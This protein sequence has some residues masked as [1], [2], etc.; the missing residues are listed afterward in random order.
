METSEITESIIITEIQ[1]NSKDNNTIEKEIEIIRLKKEIER[2]NKIIEETDFKLISKNKSIELIINYLK[3]L[4]NEDKK[5]IIAKI[6]KDIDFFEKRLASEKN[7]V[8]DQILKEIRKFFGKINLFENNFMDEDSMFGGKK[9]IFIKSEIIQ[10]K[11]HIFKDLL[12]ENNN[13]KKRLF[14]ISKHKK[15]LNI[16]K[17][18]IIKKIK[19][20]SYEKN[21]YDN[22][23][24]VIKDKIN[25]DNYLT[26]INNKIKKENINFQN[27]NIYQNYL[28]KYNKNQDDFQN[29]KINHQDYLIKNHIKQIQKENLNLE[30]NKYSKKNK[31]LNFKNE[32]IKLKIMK[33]KKNKEENKKND[34]IKNFVKSKDFFTQAIINFKNNKNNKNNKS[35]DKENE[36]FNNIIVNIEEKLD[37]MKK[38]ISEKNLK[39]KKTC[40]PEDY[41]TCKKNDNLKILEIK[42]NFNIINKKKSFQISK[43]KNQKIFKS[44]KD[45]KKTIILK[46]IENDTIYTFY[47]KKINLNNLKKK[48]NLGKKKILKKVKNHSL[49]KKL[50]INNFQRKKF[51]KYNSLE[52]PI[53]FSKKNINSFSKINILKRK[54]FLKIKNYIK[55]EK[56]DFKSIYKKNL[57]FFKTFDH[58]LKKK[59]SPSKKK[60]FI[61]KKNNI[62]FRTLKSNRDIEDQNELIFRT[63]NVNDTKK[64]KIF[65]KKIQNKKRKMK[66]KNN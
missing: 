62:F 34:F 33:E 32:I 10:K 40:I 14:K 11:N 47:D 28:M 41:Y 38:N 8:L 5:I 53:S 22:N 37:L 6:K 18:E 23:F 29:K 54:K 17:S 13:L 58:N 24:D 21:N 66:I 15:T 39:N 31:S 42:Q 50:K 19:S 3:N 52:K 26:K 9:E 46:K 64:D 59:K 20:K 30:N 27:K 25:Y 65:R 12:K 48:E 57:I 7:L 36:N 61:S 35:N 1:N 45:L 63:L 44:N 55:T 60:K 43:K 51:N 56:T 16:S 2:L 4:K 49:I